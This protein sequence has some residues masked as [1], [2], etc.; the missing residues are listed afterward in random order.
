MKRMI[1]HHWA[2]RLF[3]P[4]LFGAVAYLLTLML[5]GNFESLEEIFLSQELLFFV[6]VGYLITEGQHW[7]IRLVNVILPNQFRVGWRMLLQSVLSLA[8][9]VGVVYA[10]SYYYFEIYL[11]TTVYDTE[12][13]GFLQIWT[14]LTLLYI[15]MYFSALMHARRNESKLA[16]EMH[17]RE[18]LDYRVQAFNQEINPELLYMSLESLIS[19]IHQDN[20]QAD[21]YL[22]RLSS[23]YR[24]I[25]DRRREDLVTIMEE[26][27]AAS[28]L[29]DLLNPTYQGH[30]TLK[31]HLPT[32]V[33]EQQLVPGTLPILVEYIVRTNIISA[34]LPLTIHLSLEEDYLVIENRL[35]QR[36]QP[37]GEDERLERLQEAY[38][39]FTTRPV[40]EVK[41]GEDQFFKVPI[42][43]LQP[44]EV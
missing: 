18:L 14:V 4:P 11:Q 17:E 39:Y 29:V 8:L 34:I 10:T 5:W 41:V 43:E 9:T 15:L 31:N 21:T 25:L 3:V 44:L 1:V 26:T 16:Q 33:L 12:L 40:V 24:Y 23:V 6:T 42:L 32:D 38:S 19:L 35:C 7:L 37:Q 36:L 22:Q 28:N 30:I 27:A 2:I 20:R 13:M